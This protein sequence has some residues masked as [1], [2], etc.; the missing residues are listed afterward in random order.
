MPSSNFV[1]TGTAK[2]STN[3]GVNAQLALNIVESIGAHTGQQ[4]WIVPATETVTI[5]LAQLGDGG[6][7]LLYMRTNRV[8]RVTMVSEAVDTTIEELELR[9]TM[10]LQTQGITSIAIENPDLVTEASLIFFAGRLG[11]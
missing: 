2:L 5:N 4:E 11:S 3:G 7:H 1:V 10:L 9:G 6:A 8:V